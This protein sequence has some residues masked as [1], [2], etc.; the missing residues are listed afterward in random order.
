MPETADLFVIIPFFQRT[1]GLL[2]RAVRSVL[3]QGF[4]ARCHVIVVD[5]SSPCSAEQDLAGLAPEERAT[6]TVIRQPNG[7]AGAAR[8]TGLDAVPANARVVAFLDSDDA[9]SEDHLTRALAAIEAGAEL[10]F[11]KTAGMDDLDA[12]SDEAWPGAAEIRSP[13]AVPDTHVLNERFLAYTIRRGLPLQ[14]LVVRST[15]CRSIRFATHLHRAG[16]DLTFT[17]ALT[18]VSQLNVFSNRVE[19]SLGRGVNIYRSTLTHGSPDAIPR[20]LDE[21]QS[22]L[23]LASQVRGVPLLVTEN[24]K[25]RSM[26]LSGLAVQMLHA[27]RRGRVRSLLRI[28]RYVAVT[29]TIAG[30]LAR[31]TVRACLG[32]IRS[33]S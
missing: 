15:L 17:L 27:A 25:M 14:T 2:A 32:R 30:P 6:I 4:G 8:N 7:G 13:F 1:P 29:P 9:W 11:A 10:Y 24:A 28:A 12:P 18:R 16:E 26:T 22:R 3:A 20:L 23:D 21:V 5:D 31:E 19:A 33:P